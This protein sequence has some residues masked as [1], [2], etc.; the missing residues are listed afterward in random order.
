M[1]IYNLKPVWD[2]CWTAKNI[3]IDHWYVPNY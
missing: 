3:R 1:V 2:R